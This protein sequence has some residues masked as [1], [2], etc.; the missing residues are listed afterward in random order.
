MT[1]GNFVNKI[2][3][4]WLNTRR[5]NKDEQCC[6]VSKV[7]V[8]TVSLHSVDV[9]LLL[10]KKDPYNYFST[11]DLFNRVWL[12]FTQLVTKTHSLKG[13]VSHFLMLLN[14]EKKLH[15]YK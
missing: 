12:Q 7:F 13:T 2:K 14:R 9:T 11:G 5:W 3:C 6:V 8:I 1:K 4:K 15:S 10:L